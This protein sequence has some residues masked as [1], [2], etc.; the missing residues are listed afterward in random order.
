MGAGKP[1]VSNTAD[2]FNPEYWV[3][4]A[5]TYLMAIIASIAVGLMQAL[6]FIQQA[7]VILSTMILPVFIA[8][9]VMGGSQEGIGVAFIRTIWGVLCWPLGWG[10]VNIGAQ[11]GLSVL[12]TSTDGGVL[13]GLALLLQ[14]GLVGAWIIVGTAAVPFAISGALT[15]GANA[16]S[17]MAMNTASTV[18]GGAAKMGGAIGSAVGGIAGGGGAAGALMGGTKGAIAGGLVGGPGGAVAGAAGGALIGAIPMGGKGSGKA[19]GRSAGSLPGRLIESS[20]KHA[21]SVE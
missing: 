8:F 20:T 17:R 11:A 6:L 13:S 2:K 14:F 19:A 4:V 3:G 12:S 16:V 9:L 7:I 15:R 10:I 5:I 21:G 18:G 1:A